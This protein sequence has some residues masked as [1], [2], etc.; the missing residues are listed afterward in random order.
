MIKKEVNS[1]VPARGLVSERAAERWEEALVTGNGKMGALVYGQPLNETVILNHEKLYEP[2]HEEVV[3]NNH[4]APYLGEIRERMKRGKFRDAAELFAHKSGHPLLWTDAYHPAYALK[5]NQSEQ[6][7][8][9]NY[10]RSVDF[11]TG[12]VKV[13]WED[14]RGGYERNLFISRA[15]DVTVLQMKSIGD[16]KLNG[17]LLIED[18]IHE[19]SGTYKVMTCGAHLSFACKY[20]VSQKGYVGSSYILLKGEK[21]NISSENERFII[22]EANEIIVFTEIIPLSDYQKEEIEQ[23]NKLKSKLLTLA[24]TAYSELLKKHEQLHGEMFNRM[25]LSIGPPDEGDVA[26]ES[27]L[28]NQSQELDQ[29]LLQK[30]FDMGRYVFI[31]S[32]G[33]YPPNLVGLWTGDWRPPWSGDFTT[34]ANVNLAVSCGG[35]GNMREALEGYFHLIEK[36]SPD[37]K[38]NAQV[39]Y[40]CRGFLAG[41]KTDGNHNIHTH[42]NVDWPLGFWTAGAQWLVMPFF[43]WFQISGD[44]EFFVERALPLMKEIALFYED[45]LTEEDEHGKSLFI[46][47]YS[48]ENTPVISKELLQQ[49]WQTSQASINATMDIAV[50]KEL[51]INLIQIC[52]ELQIESENIEKWKIQLEKLPDYMINEDGALKEWIHK[53]LHDQ[54]DHRHISHLY[55]VWPGHEITPELTPELFKASEKALKLRKRGNYS[56]HGVM[57]CGIVAARLKNKELVREN[58]KLLLEGDYIYSSLVTSHNPNREIYNVDANCSVPTLVLEM[59][60]YSYPGMIELLPALPKEMTKGCLTGAL[61][62]TAVEINRLEWDLEMKKMKIVLQSKK[63]QQIEVRMRE[64]LASISSNH[65]HLVH[66]KDQTHLTVTLL[67]NEPLEININL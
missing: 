50:A 16:G 31:C 23:L 40:G 21:G 7:V 57:H 4:I 44:K 1:E 18:L 10:R 26:T 43:E 6:G 32:S 66:L 38:I 62:R 28:F 49:G 30:M 45:F 36:I 53:D 46:P 35:I 12:E 20:T 9:K 61:T 19:G 67:E 42:F 13:S 27:L 48:P 24:E 58:L 5:W 54:Y 15:D 59:L 52:S 47:S 37:W 56:A 8:I 14:E 25:S 55:P 39:L 63:D 22:E 29:R 60:I 11:E 51:L 33:D 2:F 34:D 41:S 64:G 65:A 17:E 3:Q